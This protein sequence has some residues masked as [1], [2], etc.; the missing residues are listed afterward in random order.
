MYC[1]VLQVTF[2][3]DLAVCFCTL[4]SPR[5]RSSEIDCGYVD[6]GIC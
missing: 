3:R 2:E 5:T 4:Q 1:S 6:V